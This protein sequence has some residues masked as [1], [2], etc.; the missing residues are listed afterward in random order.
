MGRKKKEEKKPLGMEVIASDYGALND[1]QVSQN[2]PTADRR[3]LTTTNAIATVVGNYYTPDVLKDKDEFLGVVL[4]SLPSQ[5]ARLSSKTQQIEAKSVELKTGRRGN[6]LFY[7]YKVYI[8]E[9]ESRCLDFNGKTTS[10]TRGDLG[11][12]SMAQRIATMQDFSLDVSLYSAAEGLRA[13][14]PGTLVK[15]VFEDLA[16]MRGPKIVE[17]FKKVFQF[18]ATGTT[19]SNVNRFNAQPPSMPGSTAGE[20]N[21]EFFWSGGK[22]A[23]TATYEALNGKD[24][25]EVTNGY[26]EDV[27]DSDDNNIIAQVEGTP[28]LK[29]IVQAHKDWK[30]LKEAYSKRFPDASELKVLGGYRTYSGQVTQRLK[31][32]KCGPS[33]R[34]DKTP[35]DPKT[36]EALADLKGKRV[37]AGTRI[38]KEGV[39]KE[40]GPAGIPGTSR[41]GWG[42]SIDLDRSSYYRP[43]GTPSTTSRQNIAFRWLNKYAIK[44][45][46]IFNV[47][48]P[49]TWHLSW[50]KAAGAFIEGKN[51]PGNLTAANRKYKNANDGITEDTTHAY[52]IAEHA[53][54]PEVAE[55]PPEETPGDPAAT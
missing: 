54:E 26:L 11:P 51:S 23:Y 19:E 9:L 22:R 39:C 55:A 31:R 1:L 53:P 4:A 34:T 8:P 3:T 13:I 18:Q 16:T 49:E 2:S 41:H 43:S 33:S 14:Q 27:T 21:N 24:H 29:L 6:P 28:K 12:L 46:W 17:I 40:G 30:D 36:N 38:P 47:K 15:I 42:I 5:V 7:T 50:T 48:P 45:N 32:I 10:R 25:I 44:Y 20:G 52:Y 37:T 35:V